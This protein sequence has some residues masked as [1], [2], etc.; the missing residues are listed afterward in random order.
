MKERPITFSS[1]MVCALLDGSKTQTRRIIAPQP[2]HNAEKGGLEWFKRD[3]SFD[4][5]HGDAVDFGARGY[6]SAADRCPYGQPG[7]RLWVRETFYCDHAYYPKGCPIVIRW[8]E[9]DAGKRVAIPMEDQRREML[10]LVSYAAD[11]DPDFED[12]PP[13]WRPSIHMPRWVSRITLEINGVRVER[14]QEIS[15]EDARAEGIRWT[16]EGPL[17]AHLDSGHN[18]ATARGAC[19][20]LWQ[21]IRGPGSWALNPWVWVVSF[22][23]LTALATEAR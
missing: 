16:A 6:P 14:L 11:G 13:P 19:Q 23:R 3:G 21:S 22:K 10:D 2:R 20:H 17:H 9:D 12:G 8:R 4:G 15:E 5:W 18:F 1:P 7:D